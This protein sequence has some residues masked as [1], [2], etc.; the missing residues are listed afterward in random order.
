VAN[1]W[2]NRKN[3]CPPEMGMVT[4]FCPLKMTGAGRLVVQIGDEPRFVVDCKVNPVAL[5]GQLNT[6]LSPEGM[7]VNRGVA[8][9]D[10]NEMLN[11][12]PQPE[13]PPPA[14]P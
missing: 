10:G 7:T 2:L 5:V 3:C 12:T 11:S 4:A 6:T 13:L 1:Y 9:T 8:P 14:T